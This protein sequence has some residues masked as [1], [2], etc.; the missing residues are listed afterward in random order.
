MPWID[1]SGKTVYDLEFEDFQK[2]FCQQC[3]DSGICVK[4]PRTVNICMGLID[5]GI[6]DTHFRKR[7]GD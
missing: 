1:L 5:S 7:K 2:L 3:K 6:W 4:D